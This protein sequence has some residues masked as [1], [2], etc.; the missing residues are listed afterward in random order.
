MDPPEFYS[1]QILLDFVPLKTRGTRY[2]SITE[3]AN[4]SFDKILDLTILAVV[5][6]F[7][8]SSMSRHSLPTIVM[9]GTW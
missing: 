2:R 6:F 1:C 7:N 3:L 4:M 9:P 8:F 5:S